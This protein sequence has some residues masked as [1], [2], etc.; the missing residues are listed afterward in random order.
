MANTPAKIQKKVGTILVVEDDASLRRLTQV[1]LDK[2]GYTT[3]V[4][5]DVPGGLEILRREPVDLVICDLHLPGESGLDLLRKVRAQ[6]PEIKFVIVT[7]YGSIS[8]AIEALKAGAHDYL[9]KPLHPLELRTL[10]DRVFEQQR[11]VEEVHVLRRSAQ[12]EHGFESLIGESTTLTNVI[13]AAS[14]AARTDAAV[15]ITGE[16]GTGKEVLA[17]AI[18]GNSERRE[19]PFV[20]V[21]CGSIPRDL[22]E[23]E[24][25]GH[26]KG[27]FTGAVA[28]K[29]GR[30]ELADGGTLFLDEIGEMPP[31]MQV[32]LLR[33]VQDGEIQKIGASS[34]TH[35]DVR[36]IA[37]THRNLGEL[38]KG[39]TF[40]EDLYYRLAVVPIELPPL[41][42]RVEDIP[43]FV[44][45]FFEQSKEKHHRQDLRLPPSLIDCFTH[46]H[47]PGNVRQLVN[48][49]VRLVVLATGPE[50]TL[51]DLPEFLQSSAPTAV[52]PSVSGDSGSSP[53][54]RTLD[55]AE[56]KVILE[57]LEKFKWN[58]T[59]AAR[60]LGVT[61]K[62]LR[63]RL[64]K[65][66]IKKSTLSWAAPR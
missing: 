57:A 33:L 58:Q 42:K 49:I 5:A 52:E 31:E 15:L 28:N 41:R 38:I 63:G 53:E 16:T 11:L 13:D 62:I 35:V 59:R 22:V 43:E 2:L 29:Q 14:R 45:Y 24:L 40:R 19:R 36:I 47:W 4:A 32:R 1:Q 25:F 64:T 65:Y 17:K 20:I 26:V 60:Y 54:D 55:A 6:Y 56:R 44:Q 21:N 23:S 10:V 12:Q 9:T 34:M 37:A 48:C 66:G 39:G 61:R 46:Y 50:I 51:R 8:T 27:A 7:A 18:H 30:A 3:R